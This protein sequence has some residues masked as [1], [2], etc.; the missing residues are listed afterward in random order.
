MPHNVSKSEYQPISI[1]R[2]SILDIN[3]LNDKHSISNLIS[4]HA[5]I[6]PNF[7]LNFIFKHKRTITRQGNKGTINVCIIQEV[8]QI[9]QIGWSTLSNIIKRIMRHSNLTGYRLYLTYGRRHIRRKI[10]MHERE[11]TISETT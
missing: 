4:P 1:S 2:S 8:C 5:T 10:M 7:I 11:M 3:Q 9:P 6:P